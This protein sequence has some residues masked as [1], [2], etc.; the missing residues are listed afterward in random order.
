MTTNDDQR[1]NG[2]DRESIYRVMIIILALA[3]IVQTVLLTVIPFVADVPQNVV[4]TTA[5]GAFTTLGYLVAIG[6]A[7]QRPLHRALIRRV[8][9]TIVG[10]SVVTTV[11]VYV[12][13]DSAGNGNNVLIASSCF[14]ALIIFCTTLAAGSTA[15][16]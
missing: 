5:L 1:P 13:S 7:A 3:G 11:L 4:F 16:E 14:M 2:I 15:R 6:V 12:W 10:V 8:V 9:L